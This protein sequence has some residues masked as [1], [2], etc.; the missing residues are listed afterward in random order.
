MSHDFRLALAVFC[1]HYHGGQSSRLYR[2]GCRLGARLSRFGDTAEAAISGN[3]H[4]RKEHNISPAAWDEWTEARAHYRKLK[5]S[6]Y[7]RET[8]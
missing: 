3:R 5:H 2:I 1:A 8:K 6:R 7:A 4:A